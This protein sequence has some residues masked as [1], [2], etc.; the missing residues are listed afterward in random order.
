MMDKSAK[1]YVAGHNGMV[2]SAIVRKL[3]A[4]GYT[5]FVFR[6]SKE[7]DLRR[8][9]EVEAFFAKE[10]PEYVILAAAKVGGIL[11]NKTYVADFAYDNLMIAANVITAAKNANV[12]KLLNLGS[13]CI[14]PRLAAQPIKESYLLTG[15]LEPTNEPYAVAKIAAIK[16]CTAYNQQYGTNFISAMP[17]NLYGPGDNFDLE[18]SHVLP[19]L[20]R[21]FYLAK[22]RTAGDM[23]GIRKN[24]QRFDRKYRPEWSEAE[25]CAYLDSYGITTGS[26]RLWGTGS[27][28]REF[29]YVDDLAAACVWLMQNKDVGDIGEFINIGSGTDQT[30]KETAELVR[31]VLGFAGSLEWDTTKPDGM[32]RKLL[33]VTR[34]REL[35]WKQTVTLRE[36]IARVAATF[37]QA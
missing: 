2:G 19:A 26:V 1:I 5:N 13:S 8:Q 23:A 18:S 27:P 10:Q 21:K 36:G 4:D 29:L 9:A 12:K 37:D 25:V 11:A 33:D 31:D 16:L 15:T 28:F 17:C 34:I 30:I 3:K 7:L 6:T 32:P 20:I 14:Y 22:K 35:G 24:L